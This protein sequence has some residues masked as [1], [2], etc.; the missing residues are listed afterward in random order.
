MT[1]PGIPII[2]MVNQKGGVG[3]STVTVCL[4]SALSRTYDKRVLVIDLDPQ[5]HTT[6][7]LRSTTT[8]SPTDG[9]TVSKVLEGGPGGALDPRCLWETSFGPSV[10]IIPADLT[11]LARFNMNLELNA[12]YKLKFALNHPELAERFDV[13]LIDTPADTGKLTQN[14]L[15]AATD[16]FIVSEPAELSIDGVEEM[17]KT[18]EIAQHINPQLNALGIVLNMVERRGE[19]RFRRGELVAMYGA[20]VLIDMEIPKSDPLQRIMGTRQRPALHDVG[21]PSRFR[22]IRQPFDALAE[23]ALGG[24]SRDMKAVAAKM[25]EALADYRAGMPDED[26][27][28]GLAE[29][30]SL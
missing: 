24:A 10:S 9:M 21:P 1:T 5:C 25:E 29:V 6:V 27:E 26:D 30:I 23:Y 17:T 7:L 12:P 15:I 8:S 4:A 20:D 19:P 18:I 2:A 14:A 22:S 13:V 28:D 3:K 11:E 16:T